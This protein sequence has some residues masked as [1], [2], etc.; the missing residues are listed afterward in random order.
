MKDYLYE[1]SIN[2]AAPVDV[3]D[4]GL[5]LGALTERH[6][7]CS[8]LTLTQTRA[9]GEPLLLANED[10]I[11]LYL[12]GRCI[13][14]GETTKNPEHSY[15]DGATATTYTVQNWWR[16]MERQPYTRSPI[17]RVEIGE[18]FLWYFDGA[19]YKMGWQN[20][21]G[22]TPPTRAAT[23]FYTTKT[24]LFASGVDANDSI[25]VCAQG[26]ALLLNLLERHPGLIT[27]P[28]FPWPFGVWKPKPFMIT[29][30]RLSQAMLA[31][32]RLVPTGVLRTG[33]DTGATVVEAL[34]GLTQPD[35][36]FALGTPPV[37][38]ARLVPMGDLIPAGVAV[39][40]AR[41][42]FRSDYAPGFQDFS[43]FS[44]TQSWWPTETRPDDINVMT[45]ALDETDT[46]LGINYGAMAMQFYE[47]VKHLAADG[48]VSFDDPGLGLDLRIGDRIVLTGDG[49]VEHGRCMVQEVSH[50]FGEC[51]TTCRVGFPAPLG[52]SDMVDR[53]QWLTR[54]FWG[55]G[56]QTSVLP[57][58]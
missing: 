1:I 14:I 30:A 12:N 48:E 17:G 10:A 58:I 37:R 23:R 19:N 55:G 50:R 41:S 13:F 43:L 7:A 18:D 5:Q 57:Y 35:R 56:R 46:N 15:V 26:N 33:Y 29:D 51:L 6:L 45:M 3:E 20:D 16:R 4:L 25:A 2:G 28:P 21:S 31:V 27:E 40:L 54:T 49:S 44:V 39:R 47:Q 8:T 36:E 34:E 32:M 9:I 11:K 42:H 22:T 24:N 53:A 52:L 38:H